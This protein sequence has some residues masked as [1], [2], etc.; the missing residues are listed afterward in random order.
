MAR[1]DY[2]EKTSA[3]EIGQLNSRID[4]LEKENADLTKNRVCKIIC[5]NHH[6]LFDT[7]IFV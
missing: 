1:L 5:V 2:V 3:K 7:S 6:R 4:I